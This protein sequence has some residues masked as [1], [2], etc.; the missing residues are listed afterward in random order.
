MEL[1]LNSGVE[2]PVPGFGVFRVT[3]PVEC[4]NNVIE[5]IDRKS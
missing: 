2:M 1:I 5:K 3:V 4:K